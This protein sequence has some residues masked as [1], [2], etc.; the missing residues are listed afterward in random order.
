MICAPHPARLGEVGAGAAE[1]TSARVAELRDAFLAMGLR[2]LATKR[3]YEELYAFSVA[4]QNLAA[5]AVWALHVQKSQALWD[6]CRRRKD[7]IY[8]LADITGTNRWEEVGPMV[9][10]VNQMVADAQ[11]AGLNAQ[12]GLGALPLAAA[13]VAVL[14]G[15]LAWLRWCGLKASELEES[16]RADV[17]RHNQVDKMMEV[18]KDPR[19]PPEVR[20]GALSIAGDTSAA[21]ATQTPDLG[22]KTSAASDL[23]L[24]LALIALLAFGGSKLLGGIGGRR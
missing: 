19:Q 24:P 15:L 2:I 13:V 22:T 20:N 8:E 4:S 9:Q 1:W 21:L 11:R 16:A 3:V 6:A 7:W 12:Q 14:A 10:R 18:A 17:L 23:V 5:A